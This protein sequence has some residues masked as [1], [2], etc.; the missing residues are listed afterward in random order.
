VDIP[1]NDAEYVSTG[2]D[3][4]ARY[5]QFVRESLDDQFDAIRSMPPTPVPGPPPLPPG[6]MWAASAAISDEVVQTPATIHAALAAGVVKRAEALGF[7][8]PPD[9]AK[10]AKGSD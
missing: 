2:V 7:P 3:E 8:V 5:A 6:S 9:I 1:E 10:R 4:A